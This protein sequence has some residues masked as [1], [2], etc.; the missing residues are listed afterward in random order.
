M[1]DIL[2]DFNQNSNVSTSFIKISKY[3]I[4]WLSDELF[5]SYFTLKER[6]EWI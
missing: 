6:Y 1:S 2:L 4:P 5:Y 3:Q